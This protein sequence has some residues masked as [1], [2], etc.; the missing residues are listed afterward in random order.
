MSTYDAVKRGKASLQHGKSA[1][2]PT[3]RCLRAPSP[4]RP[5]SMTPVEYNSSSGNRNVQMLQPAVLMPIPMLSP[6]KP[7]SINPIPPLPAAALPASTG[8]PQRTM[9]PKK[10]SLSDDPTAVQADDPFSPEALNALFEPAKAIQAADPFTPEA[11]NTLFDFDAKPVLSHQSPAGMTMSMT[12]QCLM[13]D[14]NVMIAAYAVGIAGLAPSHPGYAPQGYGYHPQQQLMQ[15]PIPGYYYGQQPPPIQQQQQQAYVH[16][17]GDMPPPGQY[18]GYLQNA[19]PPAVGYPQ[20]NGAYRVPVLAG[21]APSYGSPATVSPNLAVMGHS[22]A[23]PAPG[24]HT[25]SP[26]SVQQIQPA[27]KQANPF[28][29][30]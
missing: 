23:P 2:L 1:V 19:Y 25:S 5:R 24:P 12:M 21:Y 14:T 6:S 15:Q 29:L 10:K 18:P 16:G 26:A 28:D 3:L 27:S 20:S 11:L 4:I 7:N 22:G 30:Y 9:R 13:A 8:T 17:H